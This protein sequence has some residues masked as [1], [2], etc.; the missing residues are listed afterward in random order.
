MQIGRRCLI[1]AQTGIS[2]STVVGDFVMMGGQVG[3]ADN[4]SIA[5]GVM[6]A[7]SSRVGFDLRTAGKYGGTPA[8]PFR[9]WFKT[10]VALRRLARGGGAAFA[11]DDKGGEQ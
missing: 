11:K 7:A 8:M 4:I 9:E 5:E 10:I 6:L 3:V 1:A 2:G